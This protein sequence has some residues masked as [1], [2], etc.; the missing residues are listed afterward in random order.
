MRE[1]RDHTGAVVA[2]RCLVLFR[3]ADQGRQPIV[4]TLDVGADSLRSLGMIEV[5]TNAGR[6]AV[7]M[8]SLLVGLADVT[9]HGV[10]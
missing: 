5:D 1:R 6:A 10:D 4:M 3:D 2:Y 8:F 7:D 9:P